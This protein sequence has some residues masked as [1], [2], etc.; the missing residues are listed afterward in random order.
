M[1]KILLLIPGILIALVSEIG[2]QDWWL[3]LV[4]V[5]VSYLCGVMG[6]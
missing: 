3:L 6:K 1:T 2:T 4:A 5:M